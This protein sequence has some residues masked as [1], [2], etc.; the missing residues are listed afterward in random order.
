MPASSVERYRRDLDG[1]DA[2][3]GGIGHDVISI[4]R[5]LPHMKKL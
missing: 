2:L 4:C 3:A 5:R 1:G